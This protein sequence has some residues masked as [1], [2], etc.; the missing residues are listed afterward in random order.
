MVDRAIKNE[1]D[2][3]TD[4]FDQD[5]IILKR[6]IQ[7]FNMPQEKRGMILEKEN[8]C[9]KGKYDHDKSSEKNQDKGLPSSGIFSSNHGREKSRRHDDKT[10][11]KLP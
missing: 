11:Y 4:K 3:L 9:S 10:Y 8:Q 2:K 1:G 7:K 5:D 6:S